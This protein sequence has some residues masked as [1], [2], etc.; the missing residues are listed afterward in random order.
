[1][2]ISVASTT[3]MQRK[4]RSE[5]KSCSQPLAMAYTSG[6]ARTTLTAHAWGTAP[7]RYGPGQSPIRLVCCCG[8]FHAAVGFFGRMEKEQEQQR[9]AD[10]YSSRNE[11]ELLEVNLSVTYFESLT[12][13]SPEETA[14][15]GPK[16]Q[17][18]EVE[19]TLSAGACIL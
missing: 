11:E 9:R 8:R 19:Q 18:Q 17:D 12:K 1:M 14:H 5:L 16:T 10:S 2:L 3:A 13:R 15:K 7:A 4:H 6:E